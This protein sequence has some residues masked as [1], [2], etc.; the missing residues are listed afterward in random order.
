MTQLTIEQVRQTV[1]DLEQAMS[2]L[3]KRIVELHV[4]HRERAKLMAVSFKRM[5]DM[6]D[7]GEVIALREILNDMLQFYTA[8]GLGKQL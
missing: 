8:M 4:Q 1:Y 2:A 3:D 5:I 6:H 7:R